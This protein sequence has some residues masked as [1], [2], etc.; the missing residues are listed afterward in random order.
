MA[1]LLLIR[2]VGLHYPDFFVASP[3]RDK[4]D[5]AAEQRSAAKLT[6][7]IR[8]KFMGDLSGA[9]IVH[10]AEI[11]LAEDLGLRNG[12]LPYV[13]QPAVQYQDIVL[14]RGVTERQVIRRDRRRGPVREPGAA[15]RAW[16]LPGAGGLWRRLFMEIGRLLRDLERIHGLGHHLKDAGAIQ[17]VVKRL[18]ERIHER[19]GRAAAAQIGHGDG[20][21][22]AL[23]NWDDDIALLGRERQ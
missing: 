21:T 18:I 23:G 15:T 3:A 13:K 1:D 9:G 12:G 7:N 14:D 22:L 10:G 16:C 2:A 6:D 19:L 5:L 17:I 11:A 20:G 8:G 4:I